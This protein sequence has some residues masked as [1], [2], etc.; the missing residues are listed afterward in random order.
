[1]VL[2]VP[3]KLLRVGVAALLCSLSC[4]FVSETWRAPVQP[5]LGHNA[6]RGKL[7]RNSVAVTSMSAVADQSPGAACPIP[8]FRGKLHRNFAFILPF[9]GLKLIELGAKSQ[10]PLALV[11]AIVFVLSVEAILATSA[12]LHTSDWLARARRLN[13]EE[14][15]QAKLDAHNAR[16][17]TLRAEA[18][19]AQLRAL[20]NGNEL[21]YHPPWIR[22]ADYSMIFI[23]IAGIYS[24]LGAQMI[25]STA[26]YQHV[27]LPLVWSGAV[28]GVCSKAFF[29]NSP[30]WVEACAFLTMGWSCCLG[31]GAIRASLTSTQWLWLL[32]GGLN[33][34]V[35]V[36]AFVLQW[37]DYQWHQKF[38]RAHEAFHLGTIGGFGCFFI[39]MCSLLGR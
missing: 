26:I 32:A 22:L 2:I 20:R 3:M 21:P 12:A 6:F 36:S 11:H 7:H 34:S 28:L 25:G 8:K 15:L 19:S 29:I 13:M 27:I 31:Y 1:M 38:F 23:G 10:R 9:A 4:A 33:F 35:G 14:K 18:R 5:S 39:L 24:S 16:G 37:P 30:R 17:S